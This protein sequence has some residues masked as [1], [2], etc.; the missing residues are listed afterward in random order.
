MRR[1]GKRC[2]VSSAESSSTSTPRL[3]WR[4]TFFSAWANS[5]S[6]VTRIRYPCCRNGLDAELR[7]EALEGLD[8]VPSQLDADPVGVLVPDAAAGQRRRSR[9]YAVALDHNDAPDSP[10]RQMVG[11]AH[12]H[13][14][15]AH[16]HHVGPARHV[17]PSLCPLAPHP[18]NLTANRGEPPPKMSPLRRRGA[19]QCMLLSCRGV[20]GAISGERARAGRE[21]DEMPP[22]ITDVKAY[23]L[24]TRTALVRALDVP[25][26]AGEHEYTRWPF[27]DLIQ[28]VDRHEKTRDSG[29]T[30]KPG[31]IVAALCGGGSGPTRN[32][33]ESR[34]T[35]AQ[36]GPRDPD[37]AHRSG[38][39]A[40]T[41]SGSRSAARRVE[42]VEISAL[43]HVPQHKSPARTSSSPM[44]SS[45]A[46]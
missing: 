11:G 15:S 10:P 31:V 16:D 43:L 28:I 9:A 42:P 40:G 26:S 8:A 19:E 37:R 13:D 27:R 34:S 46:G 6:V 20:S 7:F 18:R 14:A 24:K 32:S 44:W 30:R 23:P 38:R 12:A 2:R 3:R 22:K 17:P 5:P 36:R 39:P 21:R 33:P 25:V 41:P 29:S 45:A 1:Y 35:E 4:S